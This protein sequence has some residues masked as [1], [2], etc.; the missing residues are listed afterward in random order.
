MTTSPFGN[1]LD[2]ERVRER[3]SVQQL[4]PSLP[5]YHHHGSSAPRL[6]QPLTKKMFLTLGLKRDDFNSTAVSLNLNIS[7]SL[8]YRNVYL[9]YVNSVN[10]RLMKCA[11]FCHF[12]CETVKL[13]QPIALH[14]TWK[15]KAKKFSDHTDRF[16]KFYLA[17]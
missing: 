11:L 5:T 7:V 4:L 10:W 16:S 13:V 6:L 1:P 2:A 12:C 3:R 14:K 15:R 17:D 8:A 9:V